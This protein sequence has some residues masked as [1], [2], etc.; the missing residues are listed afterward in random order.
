MTLTNGKEF[1][2]M[3]GL[4]WYDYGARF[5][6]ASLGRWQTVDPLAE[7]SRRWSPYNYAMDNPIRFI[8]PDGMAPLPPNDYFDPITGNQ[9]WRDNDLKNDNVLIINEATFNQI[10]EKGRALNQDPTD[11]LKSTA[12]TLKE[13][14]LTDAAK[15]GIANYYYTEAGYDLNEL[16]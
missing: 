2:K 6:D 10:T 15:A 9:L 7:E 4:N 1:E 16:S 3:N 11:V 5:Y 12:K 14:T 8:D 13:A